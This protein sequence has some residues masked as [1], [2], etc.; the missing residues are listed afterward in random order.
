MARNHMRPKKCAFLSN[1]QEIN[2]IWPL[3][4]C[5][6]KIRVLFCTFQAEVS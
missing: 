5:K 3:G 6:G 4:C 1:W 2:N